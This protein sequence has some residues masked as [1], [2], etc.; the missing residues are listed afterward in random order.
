ME[1]REDMKYSKSHEWV[2]EEGD[3]V[4]IG[5]TDYAQSELGD[6]VFVNLPE[7]GDELTVGESFADVESVKA[8]SDVYAPVSGVVSE[9]NEEL[10]DTPELINEAPYDAWFVKVKE[11]SEKEE[12]L[13]AGEYQA[14]VESEKE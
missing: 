2:K 12:L 14:F 10:L 4:V 5:L 11:I 6:L 8:V 13:S 1:L 3:E 9:I 7:E